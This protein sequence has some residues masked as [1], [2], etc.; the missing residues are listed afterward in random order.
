M[1]HGPAYGDNDILALTA[2]L[3]TSCLI[4][5]PLIN[6]ST[7][8]RH[9]GS[10]DGR[11]SGARTIIIYWGALV[12]VG[13]VS[14]L[15]ITWSPTPTGLNLSNLNPIICR[16]VRPQMNYFASQD[17]SWGRFAVNA[18]W[19]RENGCVD[20]CQSSLIFQP[21]IFRSYSDLQLLTQ[22]NVNHRLTG[23][24]ESPFFLGY[25]YF[26]TIVGMFLLSQ[27]IWA[28][29]FGRRVPRQARNIIYPFL[30]G[31]SFGF[32]Y[33]PFGID[34][35][36]TNYWQKKSAKYTALLAYLW[37]VT[38]SVVSVLLFLINAIAMEMLLSHFPQNESAIHIGAWTPWANIGLVIFAA[39]IGKFHDT[40]RR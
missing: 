34:G 26:G 31:I 16:P 19:I 3:S 30:R 21:A 29:C 37:A 25:T 35:G 2:I 12:A 33:P 14:I 13:L 17:P 8:L 22:A 38:A 4:T 6:W 5:V 39:F 40:L 9:L 1:W 36:K 27:A 15:A 32:H 7:T 28:L 18:E 23:V 20:P 11:A 10:R 24:P